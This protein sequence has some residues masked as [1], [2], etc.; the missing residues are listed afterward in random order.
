[1][2]RQNFLTRESFVQA[3][4]IQARESLLSVP[5]FVPNIKLIGE[6]TKLQS[7]KFRYQLPQKNLEYHVDVTILPLNTQYTR[8][9]LHGE[10]TNGESFNNDADMAIALHDFESAIE[11]ALKGDVSRYQPFKPREKKPKNVLQI[12][13]VIVAS[14]GIFLLRKKL[15]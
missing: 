13:A 1:M 15:S 3:T 8:I 7:L 6:N 14:A 11:A 5:V 4:E 2:P 12:T 10:H 9:C